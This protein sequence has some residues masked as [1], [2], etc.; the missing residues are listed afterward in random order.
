MVQVNNFDFGSLNVLMSFNT[1]T[2]VAKAVL[3]WDGA[4]KE[5]RTLKATSMADAVDQAVM[6]ATHVS[7]EALGLDFTNQVEQS[8]T[9]TL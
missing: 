7:S 4:A 3:S 8:L 2:K 1:E 5:K 6:I 9:I